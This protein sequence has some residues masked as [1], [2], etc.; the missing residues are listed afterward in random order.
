MP[1]VYRSLSAAVL[2]SLGLTLGWARG[3]A[4]ID[5]TEAMIQKYA[6]ELHPTTRSRRR[7]R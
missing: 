4:A 2:A 3:A 5:V 6:P 7:V 1:S